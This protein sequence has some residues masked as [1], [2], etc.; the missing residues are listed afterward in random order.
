MQARQLARAAAAHGAARLRRRPHLT[1]VTLFLTLRCNC[2]CGYCDFPGMDRGQDWDGARFARLLGALAHHGTARV[3]ISGGEPLL[4]PDFEGIAGAANAGGFL[5]SLVTNGIRLDDH[6]D[7]ARAFDYVLCTIE[8]DEGRH[9]A[10]RGRGAY[11]AALRGLEALARRGRPRLGV[12]CPVHGGNASQAGEVLRL[13][14]GLGA[15]AFFQPVQ[16]RGAWQGGGFDAVL[17]AAAAREIFGQLRRWRRQGRP[18][19]N[20]DTHL[21]W[22]SEGFPE[23]VEARCLAGRYFHTVLP[24]GAL[25]PCCMVDWDAHRVPLDPDR[26]GDALRGGP[27]PCDGCS[28]LPYVDNTLLLRPS[29]RTLGNALR[30]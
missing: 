28:I 16:L 19:G 7:S 22:V 2:R 29:L 30:W 10:I 8:G 3:G 23:R 27:P 26:P 6:L 14:E 1:S 20:S 15:K 12:I 4:H 17:D 5:T 21:R 24:D 18:V 9:D 13:A 11:G 25:L